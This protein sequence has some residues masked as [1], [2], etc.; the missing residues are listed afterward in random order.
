MPHLGV[1]DVKIFKTLLTNV[2]T[3]LNFSQSKND[4]L[5]AQDQLATADLK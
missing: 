3:D 4:T 5:F 1:G 2:A